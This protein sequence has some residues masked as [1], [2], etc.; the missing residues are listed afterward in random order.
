MVKHTLSLLLIFLSFQPLCLAV[1]PIQTDFDSEELLATPYEDA[2]DFDNIDDGDDE[3]VQTRAQ[4]IKKFI[5]RVAPYAIAVG[6]VGLLVYLYRDKVSGTLSDEKPQELP[7][8]NS[9]QAIVTTHMSSNQVSEDV[10]EEFASELEKP[11]LTPRRKAEKELKERFDKARKELV[12]K[13]REPFTETVLSSELEGVANFSVLSGHDGS[14]KTSRQHFLQE[15]STLGGA[16]IADDVTIDFSGDFVAGDGVDFSCELI[17]KQMLER[18]NNTED[19]EKRNTYVIIRDSFDKDH[20]LSRSQLQTSCIFKNRLEKLSSEDDP[21]LEIDGPGWVTFYL[22]G[23]ANHL[24]SFIEENTPDRTQLF[25]EYKRMESESFTAIWRY[26]AAP[27]FLSLIQGT[28]DL[29]FSHETHDAL[30]DFL[31]YS[32]FTKHIQY[33]G[34]R[35]EVYNKY[36][37]N[38]ENLPELE[39]GV[40]WYADHPD[41]PTSVPWRHDFSPDSDGNPRPY[42]Q[43]D[44]QNVLDEG[45]FTTFARSVIDAFNFARKLGAEKDHPPEGC[46]GCEGYEIHKKLCGQHGPDYDYSEDVYF[47]EYE[48]PKLTSKHMAAR[49]HEQYRDARAV[50]RVSWESKRHQFSKIGWLLGIDQEADLDT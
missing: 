23:I 20:V 9:V 4:R 29:A 32:Y 6:S 17:R 28:V 2:S 1:D 10:S 3:P 43:V 12:K 34:L 49:F 15:I 46:R 38:N 33:N 22:T 19:D 44:G 7:R 41:L 45:A 21:V 11:V 35:Y 39:D 30:L 16:G 50:A 48:C 8:S 25:E 47:I 36:K 42:Y 37:E 5:K 26:V 24:T 14:E 40:I 31:A 13:A 18:F 27:N